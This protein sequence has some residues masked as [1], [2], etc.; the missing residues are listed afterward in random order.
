MKKAKKRTNRNIR[1]KGQTIVIIA[2]AMVGLLAVTGLAIDGGG[3]YFLRR[4]TQNATD[5]A[6]LAASYAK[7]GGGTDAQAIAAAEAAAAENGF[8][9]GVDNVVV[10]VNIPPTGGGAGVAGNANFVEVI[11]KAEKTKYFAQLVYTG[12]LEVS[13]SAIGTCNAAVGSGVYANAI[14]ATGVG[15]GENSGASLSGAGITV[16]GGI[17]SNSDGS[18]TGAGTTVDGDI[19]IVDD[20]FNDGGGIT[21]T[22]GGINPDQDVFEAP[23]L[24][25]IASFAPNGA[26]GEAARL[27]GKYFAYIVGASPTVQYDQQG[28]MATAQVPGSTLRIKDNAVGLIYVRGMNKVE[29]DAGAVP[30]GGTVTIVTD[31]DIDLDLLPNVGQYTGYS[32]DLVAFTIKD[33][34]PNPPCKVNEGIKMS[35]NHFDMFGLLYAP[36]AGINFSA[37]SNYVE[38]AVIAEVVDFSG[39]DNTIIYNP[40]VIPEI[41]PTINTTQ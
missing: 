35:G 22:G 38:G 2:F 8:V 31:G 12:P 30:L 23:L 3:L 5:A 25:D 21:Q 14:V 27:D 16:I 33:N 19:D 6:V 26:R 24:Y 1:E 11:I 7:C 20:D 41:P 4:D 37:A 13:S 40:S 29:I 18:A 34:G 17:A 39:S 36:Y 32:D 28:I 9:D 10:T 15:C